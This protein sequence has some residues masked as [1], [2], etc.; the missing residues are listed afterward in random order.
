[1][2]HHCKLADQI[3]ILDREKT[4]WVFGGG[5]LSGQAVL[6]L[7]A[8]IARRK[9][10]RLIIFNMA[11]VSM[12]EFCQFVV[13]QMTSACCLAFRLGANVSAP[14][15]RRLTAMLKEHNVQLAELELTVKGGDAVRSAIIAL[16][17]VHPSIHALTVSGL[18]DSRPDAASGQPYALITALM[19]SPAEMRYI[20]LCSTPVP[21]QAALH[22]MQPFEPTK[23]CN[24]S[25]CLN[26][27]RFA[28][29]CQHDECQ[30][31]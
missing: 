11:G 3:E 8:E 12:R 20:D 19:R 22:A 9:P 16:C 4:V 31:K 29:L 2:Q 28:I 17:A 24:T 18:G 1:M 25:F 5:V 14:S 27:G 6:Q 21:S 26:T 30:R 15:I 10:Q 7:G 23:L 13:P